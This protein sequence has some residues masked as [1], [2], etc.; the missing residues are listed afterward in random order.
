MI[1]LEKSRGGNTNRRVSLQT[2]RLPVV[3]HGTALCGLSCDVL[4]QVLRDTSISLK[5]NE[6]PKYANIRFNACFLDYKC[7]CS[8]RYNKQLIAQ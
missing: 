4:V 6:R 2:S 5:Q 3:S 7:S 8:F 1:G